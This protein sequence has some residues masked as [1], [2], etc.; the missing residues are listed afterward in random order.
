[1]PWP[2][3]IRGDP[4]GL[5]PMNKSRSWRFDSPFRNHSYLGRGLYSKQLSKV[6]NTILKKQRLVLRKEK[7][8]HHHE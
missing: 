7:L 4:T 5:N 2:P 6:Y 8:Q 1:M 3:I